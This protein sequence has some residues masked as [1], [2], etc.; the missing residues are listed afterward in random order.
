[1]LHYEKR[2]SSYRE[3]GQR[4]VRWHS[5]DDAADEIEEPA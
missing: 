3:K 1:M 2:L 4:E 5:L